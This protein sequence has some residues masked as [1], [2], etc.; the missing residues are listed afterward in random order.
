MFAQ[1]M[2]TM[3]EQDTEVVGISARPRP[4]AGN[5]IKVWMI[6]GNKVEAACCIAISTGFKANN[7]FHV[8]R[9]EK[10]LVRCGV[11]AV[12]AEEADQQ[13]HGRLPL[14]LI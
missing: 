2:L 1:K 8:I 14:V 3:I 6:T 7:D 9:D 5:A 13:P 4:A 11:H 10:D 12:S